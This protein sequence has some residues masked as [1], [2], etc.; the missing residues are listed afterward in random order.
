MIDK[1]YAKYQKY[2]KKYMKLKEKDNFYFVHDTL[3]L[4]NILSILKDGYV[5]PG[6]DIDESKKKYGK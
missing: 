5:Y 2:K 4:N 6:K 1:Y 3:N